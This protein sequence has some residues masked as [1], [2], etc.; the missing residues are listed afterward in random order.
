MSKFKASSVYSMTRNDN[1]L[2]VTLEVQG[3]HKTSANMAVEENKSFD[4]LTV[5]IKKSSNHRSLDQNA[6]LWSLLTKI[7][8]HTSGSKEKRVV[9]EIYCAMLEEANAHFEYLLAPKNTEDG[10]RKS[11]RVI[12][13]KGERI[14]NGKTL[15][16]YQVFIGSSKYNTKEMTDLIDTVIRKCDELGIK[17]SEIELMRN[18]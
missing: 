11:F 4:E 6:M 2:L 7:A 3:F 17:D 9:E 1:T 12:R 13:E 14:V 15:T 8:M 10:L 16:I 5:E 18:S